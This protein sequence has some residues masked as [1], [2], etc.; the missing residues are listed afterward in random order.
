MLTQRTLLLT[1]T[2]LLTGYL[3][4]AQSPSAGA[5]STG[6]DILFWVLVGILAIVGLM[7]MVTGASVA[8]VAR[9]PQASPDQTA[10]S[11]KGNTVC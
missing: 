3:A 6:S 5:A 7:V 9:L 4:A 8:S 1:A 10:N 11:E 2:G